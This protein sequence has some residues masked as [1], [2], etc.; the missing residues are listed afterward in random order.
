MV[1]RLRYIILRLP[2]VYLLVSLFYACANIGNPNGGPYDEKPPKFVSSKPAM[3]Q[4]NF[5]GK[6]IEV[7]FDEFISVDNP[8]ENVI[9]T[10]PQK[11]SPIIQA[12]GKKINVELRDTLKENTTYTIDF[13]SSVAD[14][15][16]K[17]V[18]ENF[19]F[20]FSTGDVL[21]TMQISGFLYDARELEPVQ[22]MIVGIHNDLSD[23]A[24]TR[25]PFLRTSKTDEKG[26]FVIHNVAPGSYHVFA[27]EDKNR[28]YAY[29]KNAD[30]SLAFLDSIIIPSCERKIVPDS[31]WKDTIINKID[32]VVF[33]S[34]AMVEKTIFY[35]NDLILWYFK[36]SIAPRQ[37]M[38]RP[39]RPQD[40]I[41]TLKF[42]A[43]LDTFP[44]PVPLNFEVPDSAWFVTQRGEDPESFAINYWVLDSMIY[45]ID[46]LM[47]EVTYWKNNDT[48]PDLLELQT[49]TLSLVNKEA[50]QKKKE[51]KKKAPKVRKTAP[52]DSLKTDSV[53][54]PPPPV[55]LKMAINPSGSLNPYDVITIVV[56]EP[57]LDVRKEFFRLEIGVDTLWEET[58]FEFETDS[59][60]AM[61]YIIKRPFKYEERY[62]LTADSALLKG[63]YGHVNDSTTVTL[64]VKGEKEYGHLSVA[65][66]GLPVL[67]D[68]S[69]AVIPAF[70]ELLG[71]SGAPVRKATVENGVALFRDMPAEKYY[72]RI[73]FDV[74]GNGVW[75]AGS[76][77]ERKQ[78]E[79]VVYFM[80]QFEIRQNWKIEETWD[81]SSA[82]AGEKPFDLLKNK[83]KET[84]RKKRRNY[85][86]ESN[87][88]RSGGSSMP[89]MGNIGG[90]IGR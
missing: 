4:L 10:P 72:A 12:I 22:K 70:M 14:N 52:K 74:N 23:T 35:P 81:V 13:T 51:K 25:T 47:V 31:I 30:E 42:N 33:D 83:P 38:L 76:Y 21:D 78:P 50:A 7:L 28:N 77:E 79:K 56:A 44:Y 17:N 65:V 8:S 62:R 63:V 16:E 66:K 32:T 27:L 90:M 61:T 59:V 5:K 88:R 84:T 69:S 58:D 15:N 67:E 39:E 48:V 3:N 86:D 80:K 36:D 54:P 20:A 43:P 34:I 6:N 26:H 89:G 71:S 41:F 73:T 53:P 40:Y 64:T 18:L 82:R 75:D 49:D 1:E 37:R 45:N 11:Q 19:S 2:A 85:R 55:P 57:V 24:F 9:V 87:P 29:D 68:D 46:T 60:R